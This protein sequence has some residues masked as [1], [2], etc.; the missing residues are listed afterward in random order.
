MLVGPGTALRYSQKLF[1]ILIH[2]NSGPGSSKFFLK[3]EQKIA[4]KIFFWTQAA[5]RNFFDHF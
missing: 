1:V 3:I 5:N 2:F 4:I